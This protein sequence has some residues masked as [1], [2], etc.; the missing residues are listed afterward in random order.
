MVLYINACVRQGSRTNRIA[1]A[2]LSKLGDTYTE[3]KLAEAGFAPLSA[4]ALEK[5]T[6]LIDSGDYSDPMFDAAKQFAG[7]DTI[8]IAA[9]FW[10]FSFPASLKVYLENIYVTGIVS[11][12][13]SDGVPVGLCRAKALY[14]VTTAGGPYVP[15]YSYTY[16]QSLAKQAFGIR[17][18]HLISAEM[19]DVEGFDAEKIVSEVIRGLQF[20]GAAQEEQI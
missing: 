16:I 17:E 13:G 2:L 19:L 11:K 14:Y 15:D 8:V 1:K 9:P 12:Y 20:G 7:A 4:E 6:A 3:L 18:T 5:R 10:D